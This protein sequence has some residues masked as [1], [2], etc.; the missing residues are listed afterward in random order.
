[1]SVRTMLAAVA[2]PVTL[3]AQGGNHVFFVPTADVEGWCHASSACCVQNIGPRDVAVVDKATCQDCAVKLAPLLAWN[4]LA[5]DADGD[6][7]YFDPVMFGEI[8]ALL[9]KQSAGSAPNMRNLFLSVKRPL[10]AAV[11]GTPRLRPGDVA[12]IVRNAAGDGQLEHF[13][14]VE[15]LRSALGIAAPIAAIDL[16][17]IAQDA[18]GNLYVSLDGDMVVQLLVAGVVTPILLQDGAVAVIPASAIGYDAR[19]NV[20]SVL[21]NGAMVL[22]DEARADSLVAHAGVN[23]AAGAPVLAIGDVDALEIDPT[24][25]G[26]LP[27]LWGGVAYSF[28]HLAFAGETLTGL[29]V[30]STIGGGSIFSFGHT[31]CCL[32]LARGGSSCL[33]GPTTGFEMG[34]QAAGGGPAMASLNALAIRRSPAPYPFFVETCTPVVTAPG[35][36]QIGL[37][38]GNLPAVLFLSV[39]ASAAGGVAAS[40]PSPWPVL[41]HPDFYAAGMLGHVLMTGRS[42]TLPIPAL[43]PIHVVMQALSLDPSTGTPV[44]STPGTLVIR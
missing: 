38:E 5:G 30:L 18:A 20:A 19:G 29:G 15:Q 17:A 32:D 33:T 42:L 10:G 27:L 3:A 11:S 24:A 37:G 12:A 43:P 4:T 44:L 41:S 31:P 22:F 21:P 40:L 26:P 8:D 23:D 13:L 6:A 36:V 9:M 2:L 14:R 39:G 7:I 35:S 1:M 25:T 28:T 34:V 16:D